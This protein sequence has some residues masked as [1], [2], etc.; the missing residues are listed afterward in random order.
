MPNLNNLKRVGETSAFTL[1]FTTI[2]NDNMHFVMLLFIC[3]VYI[4]RQS[5]NFNSDFPLPFIAR[6]MPCN[7][8]QL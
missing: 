8:Y 7:S 5:W 2:W 4:L 6:I 1:Y 3:T